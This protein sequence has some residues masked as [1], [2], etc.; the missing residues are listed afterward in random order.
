MNS[1]SAADGSLSWLAVAGGRGSVDVVGAAS[2]AG[3]WRRSVDVAGA[4]S[5]VM[6][7]WNTMPA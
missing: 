1:T 7:P 5:A 6:C 2:G 4:G 3:G